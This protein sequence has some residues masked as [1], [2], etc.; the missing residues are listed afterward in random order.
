MFLHYKNHSSMLWN[1]CQMLSSHQNRAKLKPSLYTAQCD[2]IQ[3]CDSDFIKIKHAW[4]FSYAFKM[5]LVQSL[6]ACGLVAKSCP[7]LVTPQTVA[8]QAPQSMGSQRVEDDL[9]TQKQH[10]LRTMCTYT[11]LNFIELLIENVR[12]SLIAQ[13]EKNPPA[14][15]D[16][17]V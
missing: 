3:L 7:T 1:F 12:A 14:M 16:T 15:Q 9:A 4:T 2:D 10:C 8:C 13:L 5:F 6:L 11:F 17:W